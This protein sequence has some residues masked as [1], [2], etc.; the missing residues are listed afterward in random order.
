MTWVKLDEHFVDHP[1][2]VTAGPLA[3][4]LFISG[5]CYANRLLTDGFIP[6][7]FLDRLLVQNGAKRQDPVKLAHKLCEVELWKPATSHG[8]KGYQ[9]HDFLK[10]Q[11][12][13]KQVLQARKTAADRQARWRQLSRAKSQRD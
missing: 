8:Q 13:R 11:P 10:Y 2:V 9:I 3:S 5:L 12:S 6:E 4:W 7:Q 1:K